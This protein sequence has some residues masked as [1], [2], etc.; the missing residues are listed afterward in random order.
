MPAPQRSKFLTVSN[1]KALDFVAA[2]TFES[3]PPYAQRHRI[4]TLDLTIL[5][6]CFRQPSTPPQCLLVLYIDTRSVTAKQQCSPDLA[7]PLS[8]EDAIALS[9]CEQAR[10]GRR[11]S[12]NPVRQAV[13]NRCGHFPTVAFVI[14]ASRQSPHC[15]GLCGTTKS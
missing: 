4:V 1:P 10:P 13:R 15:S 7:G 8:H 11:S 3:L 14:P 5:W 12:C 9:V 6:I 2:K